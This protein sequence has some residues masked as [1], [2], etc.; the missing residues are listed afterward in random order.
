[1]MMMMMSM[2][3]IIVARDYNCGPT[4]HDHHLSVYRRRCAEHFNQKF[5]N[6]EWQQWF[7]QEVIEV[8]QFRAAEI[9]F[10][11]STNTLTYINTHAD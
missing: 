1:M 11:T 9:K 2:M 6:A 3:I 10:D 8:S 5:D 4:I 7:D